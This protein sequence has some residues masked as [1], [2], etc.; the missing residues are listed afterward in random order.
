VSWLKT[1]HDGLLLLLFLILTVLGIRITL[2]APTGCGEVPED[3]A[4]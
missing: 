4:G 3:E 1:I 2:S